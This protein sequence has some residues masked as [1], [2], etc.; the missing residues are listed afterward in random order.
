MNAQKPELKLTHRMLTYVAQLERLT[1]ILQRGSCPVKYEDQKNL[2]IQTNALSALSLDHTTP[3]PLAHPLLT[4]FSSSK[5][6]N[7]SS[8]NIISKEHLEI[9]SRTKDSFSMDFELSE[10]GLAQLNQSLVCKTKKENVT[11]NINID[12][13]L[14]N[15][16]LS[17]LSHDNKRIFTTVSPFLV[18]RRLK[19]LVEWTCDELSYGEISPILTIGTFHLLFLQIHPFRDGNH[20]TA[21]IASWSLL[22]DCGYNFVENS[23][24]IKAFLD[25]GESYYT[26]LKHA[27]RTIFSDWSGIPLWLEFFV[28][29]LLK[30]AEDAVSAEE[31]FTNQAVLTETQ[32]QILEVIQKHGAVT[33]EKVV[34][35]TGINLS[36]VK[37]NLSLLK[38][39]GHLKREGGGRSTF[40]TIL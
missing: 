11:D 4:F 39:R 40:Y 21:L 7:F 32:K 38:E 3:A 24:F 2:S 37:Y 6:A 15:Y 28:R 35:E 33:R 29:T 27:E 18:K 30:S 5:N 19:D 36:T 23:S 9:I 26:A 10:E 34:T 8:S 22:K 25:S 1:G 16:Q 12:E 13:I 17:F 20:R 31:R 14:R